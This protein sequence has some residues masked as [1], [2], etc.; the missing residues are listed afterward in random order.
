MTTDNIVWHEHAVN[1]AARSSALGQAA[2][3]I[4]LTG[5]SGSGKSTLSG[6]LEKRLVAAQKHTYLLDG[7][8]VRHGLCGDLGF[9]DKDRVENIRRVSEVSKLFVDAGLLVLT[10]FISPFK[11]DRDYCR[12]LLDDGEFV[13]VFVDVP[14][15]ECEKRDPKG[16]YK[17]ARAGEIKDFTGISS[18]YEA[19]E[20]P[21][22]HFTWKDETPEASAERLFQMLVEKGVVNL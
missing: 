22:I 20:S 21:E 8:N 16:L 15:A 13:E 7:D 9:S 3:V 5:L 12:N 18:D 6:L 2:K 11:A 19:P 4:W 10:A 1:K 17:K 14:L